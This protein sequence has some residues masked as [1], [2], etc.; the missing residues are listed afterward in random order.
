MASSRYQDRQRRLLHT[1]R[2]I[3]ALWL[4][5]VFLLVAAGY[6]DRGPARAMFNALGFFAPGASDWVFEDASKAG[7][8][9]VVP[10]LKLH[11]FLVPLVTFGAVV[12]IFWRATERW[13]IVRFH[14]RLTARGGHVVIIGLTPD[15]LRF[16]DDLLDDDFGPAD[17]PMSRR[18]LWCDEGI[19]RLGT[20]PRR[21]PIVF[22][23]DPD[24]DL[25]DAAERLGVPLRI[26]TLSDPQV[27]RAMRLNEAHAVVSFLADPGGQ[28][29]LAVAIG[30]A[31]SARSVVQAEGAADGASGAISRLEVWLRLDNA[32]FA[33]RLDDYTQIAARADRVTLRFF[34]LYELAARDLLR[35][36]PP[37]VYADALGQAQVHLAIYG[38]GSLGE[39]VLME[40]V[41]QCQYLHT[42]RLRLTVLDADPDAA[43]HRLSALGVDASA[44][45]ELGVVD[46]D[47]A[48]L[49]LETGGIG[50]EDYA[51][52][53]TSVTMHVIAV[54]D[55]ARALAS[56][57]ALRRLL[58][59]PPPGHED[60]GRLRPLAPILVRATDRRGLGRLSLSVVDGEVAAGEG[61]ETPDGIFTFASREN[62]LREDVLLDAA[63]K[64]D[65]AVAVHRF[66]L[67]KLHTRGSAGLRQEWTELKSTHIEANR[68]VV[69]HLDV[70]LR[71]IRAVA[72]PRDGVSGA[73]APAGEQLEALAEVEH[74]RW[75]AERLIAGWRFA[76]RRLDGVKAH[77]S[78]RSWSALDPEERSKDR[79]QIA[80]ITRI[81]EAADCVARPVHVVG[82]VGET[83]LDH[84]DRSSQEA[85]RQRLE[86]HVA[87]MREL[88]RAPVVWTSLA[89][90]ADMLGAIAAHSLGVA[91]FAALPLPIEAY[92]EVSKAMEARKPRNQLATFRRL[93]GAADAATRNGQL[94]YIELPPQHLPLSN[95]GR[96]QPSN[97]EEERRIEGLREI[98]YLRAAAFIVERADAM[99]PIGDLRGSVSTAVRAWC[100]GENEAGFERYRTP[101]RF[102]F[103][104]EGRPTWLEPVFL[105]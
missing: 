79:D 103:P 60:A 48:K 37:D 32:A 24:D 42:P 28:I 90:G 39:H 15:S 38:F 57:I 98:Q 64:R 86:D 67:D 53:P 59:Q 2:I 6:P 76:E 29:E 25:V 88:G 47:F 58:L 52:V 41:R 66:Y 33:K 16:A 97:P 62:L 104:R 19:F 3:F 63:R 8:P 7:R 55:A 95:Y 49:D 105:G 102:A 91:Y 70:K 94:R 72:A 74:A 1:L 30:Q 22:D 80:S 56:A 4:F 71:A 61:A 81:L 93:V 92:E 89:P 44:L 83:A 100:Q 34:N 45:G 51:A 13:L 18:A 43:R 96:S 23:A 82:I 36:H 35:R 17:G 54:P 21:L 12:A 69:D 31:A 85:V 46:I 27:L 77:P 40:A 9:H 26:G 50:L 5:G 101:V 78:L 68:Q 75:N 65:L 99:L 73:S 11:V 87:K 84:D 14:Q 20:A 10:L